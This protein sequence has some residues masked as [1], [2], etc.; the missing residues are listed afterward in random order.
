MLY[1]QSIIGFMQNYKNLHIGLIVTYSIKWFNLN[2]TATK[3]ARP[4]NYTWGC[5]TDS[6]VTNLISTML[7]RVASFQLNRCQ[8]LNL[9]LSN[10]ISE[11]IH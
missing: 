3:A 5:L 9:R 4:F 1:F 11:L 7:R 6:E 2:H 8:I 10:F